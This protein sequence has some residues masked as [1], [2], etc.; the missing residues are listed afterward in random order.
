MHSGFSNVFRLYRGSLLA[1][2]QD[3][4]IGERT[5]VLF[6]YIEHSR[7]EVLFFEG[8]IDCMFLKNN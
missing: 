5:Q 7:C 2:G 6:P 3:L 8:I 1:L 4:K